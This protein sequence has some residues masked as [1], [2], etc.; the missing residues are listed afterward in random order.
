MKKRISHSIPYF[1]EAAAIAA[2][3]DGVSDTGTKDPAEAGAEETITLK[4]SELEAIVGNKVS[5]LLRQKDK[6]VEAAKAAAETDAEKRIDNLQKAYD[7]LLA[8]NAQKA[9]AIEIA[10]R[11]TT[12][13]LSPDPDVVALLS[14]ETDED[15]SEATVGK[16]IKG[17]QAMVKEAIKAERG[18]KT[19]SAATPSGEPD[20][21]KIM[22]EP[23]PIRQ[24][25]LIQALWQAGHKPP[26]I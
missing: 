19:P 20:W 6:A 26:A 24:A 12:A 7:A 15:K 10:S 1:D 4:K 17:I 8:E 13:K 11:F 25:Q 23:D 21:K 3:S 2:A 18:G 9:R 14:M 16:V 22:E 5:K